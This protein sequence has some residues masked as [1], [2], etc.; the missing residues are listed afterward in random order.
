MGK[1]HKKPSIWP[2]LLLVIFIGAVVG[3][4]IIL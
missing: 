1:H 2:V 3:A 4:F